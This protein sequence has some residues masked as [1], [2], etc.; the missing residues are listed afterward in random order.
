MITLAGLLIL[1]VLIVII[2]ENNLQNYVI[3]ALPG[4]GIFAVVWAGVSIRRA[5]ARRRERLGYQPLS[6]DE[7]RKARTK[8]AKDRSRRSPH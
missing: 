5:R 1:L 2:C 3:R 4:V 7:I 6:F 8:L